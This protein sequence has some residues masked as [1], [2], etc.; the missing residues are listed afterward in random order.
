MSIV[1]KRAQTQMTNVEPILNVCSDRLVFRL[2]RARKHSRSL[3]LK[4]KD[5]ENRIEHTSD[6]S[7]GSNVIARFP[8]P[9]LQDTNCNCDCNY[10]DYHLWLGLRNRSIDYMRTLASINMNNHYVISI[11]SNIKCVPIR[12]KNHGPRHGTQTRRLS[13]LSRRIKMT[14]RY[15]SNLI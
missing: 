4:S 7:T 9:P 1:R 5:L 2:R 12:K 6:M 11:V 15:K 13:P 8:P 10:R 3:T 14:T